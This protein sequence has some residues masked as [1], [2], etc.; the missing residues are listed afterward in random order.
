[1]VKRILISLAMAFLGAMN[2]QA[3]RSSILEEFRP[4]S[5]S[6]LVLLQERTTVRTETKLK[7][8]L[9]RGSTL[10]FYFSRELG[11]Y[12]WRSDDIPWFEDKLRELFPSGYDN[13]SVGNIYAL[14]QPLKSFP[15]PIISNNGRP[16]N[17]SLSVEDS[18]DRNAAPVKCL[19]DLFYDKGLSGRTIALWQ[20]HGKYYNDTEEKW[21]WQRA[22]LHRTVE[23]MYTQSYVIPF[24]IPMLENSGAY[25]MTPRERDTQVLEIITDNDNSFKGP[26]EGLTRK[27]GMYSESGK[28]SDAGAGFADTK[29]H[30]ILG[31]N[32]FLN[33]SARKVSVSAGK[34]TASARWNPLIEKNGNYSVYV[35]YKTLPESINCAHYTVHH[36][37]GNTEFQVNQTMGGGTWIY[38]GNFEMDADSYVELDNSVPD[39][40]KTRDNSVIS[41]DAVKIGGGI[42]KFERGGGTSDVPSYME[43]ALYWTQWAG[44]GMKIVEE[45]GG[46]YTKDYTVRGAWTTMM[47]K[48]KNIPFDLSLAFHSDAGTHQS[49]S[50]V[51]TLTIYSRVC[52]GATKLPDGKS[53]MTSRSFADLVQSQVCNDI[54]AQFD[55]D[56]NRRGTWD[57]SYSECRTTS[58]P[59]II[60]EL[61]SHQNFADMKCGLDPSFRFTVSRAVYK[62]ILKFLSNLYC[63]P[64]IVQ[65][66][67]V[68]SFAVRFSNSSALLSWAATD[69][70][71][72]P[73][74][75][76]QGFILKTRIDDGAFDNGVILDNVKYEEG[77]YSVEIPIT[78]GKIYSFNITA[79]NA[80]GKSFPSET[81]SIGT[82]SE[83]NG[84][85]IMILNNFY[86]LAAPSWF[87]TPS[88]AGF[89]ASTDSGVP[90]LYDISYIGENYQN[91]RELEW[92]DDD[93]PG[94]G[95]SYINKA[96]LKAAGNTFDFPI[97]HGKA[98]FDLGYAFYSVSNESWQRDRS[99]S[100]GAYAVDII[101]GKQ[102]TTPTGDGSLP[103]RFEVFTDEL[104]GCIRAYT[105]NGGNIIISGA[106]IGT[107]LNDCVYPIKVDKAARKVKAGAVASL[108]GY[109][110]KTAY[111]GP[112]G[113]V[114][115]MLNASFYNTLNEESY[116]V[117]N[118]DGIIPSSTKA[119]T[120]LKYD[121][122]GVSA[123]VFYQG[124]GYKSA[125]FGFPLEAVTDKAKLFELIRLTMN[126]IAL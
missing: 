89:D 118:A 104:L 19:S 113:Q 103:P 123:A 78:Q 51:G 28:W 30:Y 2:L 48:N 122:N 47:Q 52:D 21:M 17:Y 60:L 66:L 86:R 116:C 72:E 15:T 119:K 29:E 50:T 36:R 114:S 63:T 9:K 90:Y 43:G 88:Y 67:P 24:L 35:S 45:W 87:D 115:G 5:D 33:G 124:D 77:V 68:S 95:A 91:R 7:K 44:A 92:V 8:V 39:N 56:W 121:D 18:R 101:C 10:D 23:D 107:D 125:A 110:W 64:Y 76:P 83:H 117:E 126:Y 41:A 59:G 16:S 97:V 84:K 80:G 55:P 82:P 4:V 102:V 31:D 73:T 13:Y 3:Q 32:P 34:P 85:A 109:K 57:R 93:N 120:V 54:R 79:F 20:S 98:L 6:M 94:F 49:D 22:P 105:S 58:V 81:L 14:N 27:A 42:G 106:Y 71:L 11:D 25:V 12:P 37:G 74:A 100:T 40:V 61:L 38:L 75:S 112:S 96:G 46:D 53:R 26:R 62:G 69:D 111:A 108:L 65:P 1:M 70:S 99:L